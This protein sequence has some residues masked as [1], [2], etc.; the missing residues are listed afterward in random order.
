VEIADNGFYSQNKKNRDELK[1][2]FKELKESNQVVFTTFHQS[3]SYEEFLESLKPFEENK[4]V[5]YKIENGIFKQICKKAEEKPTEN[6]VLIIDEINRGN[7]ASI[8]GELITLIEPDKRKGEDEELSVK[9]PYSKQDFTVPK[10]LYIIGTMNTADRSVEALDSALRRRFVFEEMPPDETL[11]NEDFFEVN[12]Q[13]ILRKINLRI[14]K[15]IDKDHKIGHSYFMNLKSEI[16]LQNAFKNKI[17]PLLEEYFYGDF[18]KIGLVL[19]ERFLDIQE[20]GDDIFM[21]LSEQEG[22]YSDYENRKTY[23][24]TVPEKIDDFINDV[25]NIYL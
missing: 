15:L 16:D 5:Y 25:K 19:G 10:N 18:V 4:Q 23:K 7:I 9:L 21:K 14:E 3:M 22:E 17:I 1:R 6:F 12:L 13:E 11:L 8:F 2:R 24:T 20:G